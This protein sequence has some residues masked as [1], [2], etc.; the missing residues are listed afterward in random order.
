MTKTSSS[1]PAAALDTANL[2]REEAQ[3]RSAHLTVTGYRVELDL[4]GAKDPGQAT[5]PSTTT[6]EFTSTADS[7]FLDFIGPRVHSVTV[8][9]ATL[10]PA[11][12]YD[13]NRIQLSGLA[14]HN[15]VTVSADAAY[16]RS[17]EGLH[18]FVDPA[19]GETYLYTHYEPA[20]ARRV[21]ANF[22]QPDLKAPFTFVIDAP[23]GWHVHSNQAVATQTSEGD[24]QH[25][26]F[27]PTAPMSTYITNITTGPYHLVRDN[28]SRTLADGRTLEV[29]LG[30]LCRASLAEHFDADEILEVT[31]QGLDF[32]HEAFDYPYPWGKYDQAFVPEYNIGAMENPGCVTFNEH[33]VFR[34]AATDA[35]YAGRA[36]TILHEMAH[37]WF[38]DLVTM[39][40][41]DD[42][43]LKESFADY[44]GAHASVAATRH[45]DAWTSFASNRKAWA[46]LQDQ[47]PTTHPIVADITDLEAAKQ[48]FDG[49]T[50]AKGASVLKQLV[51]YVGVDAFFAGSRSY[52]RAHEF[53]NTTLPDLLAALEESSGR[54]LRQW[55][56]RW[57]ETAGLSTLT[58]VLEVGEGGAIASLTVQQESVDPTTGAPTLRPHRLAVGLYAVS[59]GALRRTHR[60]ELD[61]TGERTD[62]AEASGLPAPDLIL[63]NDDDLTYGKVRLDER[64][65]A[66]AREHLAVME[67]ELSR[68]LVWSAL[69]NATRDGV[70]PASDYLQVVRTQTPH[71]P[72]AAIL[73]DVLGN[74]RTAVERYL[75][76]AERQGGRAGLLEVAWQNLDTSEAGSDRQL[77]WARTV[78]GVAATCPTGA[79]RIRSILNGSESVDGLRL[80][81]DL[82]WSFWQALAATGGATEAELDAEL[83]RDRTASGATHR[84]AALSGR[85]DPDVKE[86]AWTTLTESD[87]LTNEHLSATIAGFAQPLHTDLTARYAD[88]YFAGLRRWWAERS[89]EIATRLV[90]GLYPAHQDL[91]DGQRPEE[92]PVVRQSQAWLDANVDAP[93]ALRRLVIEQQDH[94]LRA[95]GAQATARHT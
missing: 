62:V 27:A 6:I 60:L 69:W 44:M 55:S 36:N 58:P 5:F 17:G 14:D 79:E 50:Y 71:E 28:W 22:E 65:L 34:S 66:T 31:K 92:H 24:A 74:A 56:A 81:P 1:A 70:L 52:F 10:D 59:D 67:P 68:A 13:G 9:G 91:A 16:S 57:L 15:V 3:H 8:N 61:V 85:P 7:T 30:A 33:Y 48:N 35:Q 47:L 41:W 20:D 53:G 80:D 51:A 78:A 23:A 73:R 4:T 63:V 90:R 49:I 87:E 93:A 39:Q 72:D 18:R 21:F 95:L 94:L 54:D 89:I 26:E 77:V 37:M 82:R 11:T 64:S 32:F 29:P 76:A 75:P 40:W 42:L 2:S 43:W 25:V 83:E 88:R 12:C 84:I 19:D 86:R 46:Y 45:T 38:G